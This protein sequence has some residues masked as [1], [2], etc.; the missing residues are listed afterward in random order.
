MPR[1]SNGVYE[2]PDGNPVISGTIID[3]VWANNTMEDLAD[4]L[5]GSLPRNGSAS[6]TGPLLLSSS[7]PTR[8][9][10]AA[11]KAYVDKFTAYATGMPIGAIAPFAGPTAEIPGW[12][13]CNGAT[14]SRSTYADLFAAIGTIYGAGDGLL[15]FGLPDLRNEFIR[16]V[17]GSRVVGSHQESAFSAHAH[18]VTDPTHTHSAIATVGTHAHTLSAT[19]SAGGA[20]QGTAET[21]RPGIVGAFTG[22]V[23]GALSVSGDDGFGIQGDYSTPTKSVL[24][25]NAPD[26]SHTLSGTTSE[27][28]PNAWAQVFAGSTGITTQNT[29]GT[30]NVPQNVAMNYFIKA[31]NDTSGTPTNTGQRFLGYFNGTSG[32]LP[33]AVY[34]DFDFLTGDFYEISAPGMLYVFDTNSHTGSTTVVTVGDTIT[35][36]AGGTDP[37]GWYLT[38]AAAAATAATSVSFVPVGTIGATNVQAAIEEVA[39]EAGKGVCLVSVKDFGAVGDGVH[40]DTLNIQ[41]AIDSLQNTTGGQVWLPPGDYKITANL[42]ISWPEIGGKVHKTT[43]VGSGVDVSNILDY[44]AGDPAGGA[45][46]IDFSAWG[47]PGVDARYFTLDLGNFSLIKMV[48]AT[49]VNPGTGVYTPGTGNGLYLNLVVMTGQVRNLEV[50][51]YYTAVKAVD[52]LGAT[53]RGLHVFGCV[54]G[55][56]SAKNAFSQ[57]NVLTVDKSLFVACQ[58]WGI[59]TVDGSPI[60]IMSTSFQSCGDMTLTSGALG[61]EGGSVYAV[62][63]NV[64]GCYFE[65]NRGSADILLLDPSGVTEVATNTIIGGTFIRL[66]NTFYTTH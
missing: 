46:S 52:T 2:L 20:F 40:D 21:G 25:L 32:A 50:R 58:S 61:Y 54:L 3:S 17:G 34:P 28:A 29:G 53:Y 42:L 4:A 44:R 39:L 5:T 18:G 38:E 48:N 49:T 8:D 10:E 23:S 47:S 64:T 33:Q 14:V 16:G 26:H 27:V 12:L 15:T 1:N 43:L 63:M 55:L 22:V 6:M 30:E 37:E 62:G 59:H 13:L 31:V 65:D 60:N 9:L 24:N 66:S 36:V 19:T 41:A 35:W 56:D 11:S 51:G 7:T 57:P 45:V